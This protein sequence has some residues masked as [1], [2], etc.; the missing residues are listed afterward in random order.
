LII[1][2][3][4]ITSDYKVTRGYL[5]PPIIIQLAK[6]PI[7][8]K[9]DLSAMKIINSGAAPLGSDIQVF[10]PYT[11]PLLL[12]TLVFFLYRSFVLRGLMYWLN[13][14]MDSL[15]PVPLPTPSPMTLK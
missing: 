8:D 6:D 12:F 4:F 7:V 11:S 15:R 10:L 14:D 2:P 5:V 1:D 13:K 3:L 9:Y